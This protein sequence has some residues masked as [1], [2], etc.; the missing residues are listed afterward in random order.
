MGLV[1]EIEKELVRATKSRDRER[2]SAIRLI[3]SAIQNRQIEKREELTDEE[4]LQV[5]SSLVKKAKESIEQFE[6]GNRPDLVEKERKELQIILS[7][8][9]QQLSE[10]QLREELRRIVEEKGAKGL[11]DL[12]LVMRTA[13]DRLKGRAEGKVVNR[14]VRELLSSQSV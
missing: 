5:L 6:K 12:G 14:I 4:V 13:M 7:F 11:G 8:M 10:E 9:P 1:Q 2:L 3:R